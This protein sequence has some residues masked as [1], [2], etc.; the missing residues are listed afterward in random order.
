VI[1][2]FADCPGISGFFDSR[3]TNHGF[4]MLRSLS[5]RDFV[6]VDCLELEFS[7]GFTVLTG[8]TGAGKSILIGALAMVLGER[9]DAIVV[10]GGGVRWDGALSEATQR[11][12]VYALRLLRQGYAPTI[13]LTGGNPDDPGV[14]ESAEMARVARE[15]GFPAERFIVETRAS[16][17]ST[18]ARAVAEIARAQGFRSV[19]LVT[20]PTHSYR[21][22]L[23]FRKAGV[24]A[25]PGTIDPLLRPPKPERWW[26]W[27]LALTPGKTLARVNLAG[28]VS[29][30]YVALTLYWY[31]GWI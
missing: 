24:E 14:P 2:R 31:R 18:Q 27:W 9:A 20:S 4:L 16:R 22:L 11:R 17:T 15:L 8:E 7:P 12:L 23:A 13:I 10:L 5:I 29:Y 21:A 19:I 30:E 28:L 1:R 26:H 6:I 3:I 25:F